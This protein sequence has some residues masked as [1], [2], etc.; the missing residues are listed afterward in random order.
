MQS[1]FF[2]DQKEK[3][4]RVF[5]PEL[6]SPEAMAV[7]EGEG[8]GTSGMSEEVAALVEEDD[9]SEEDALPV[10]LPLLGLEDLYE[11]TV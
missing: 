9:G 1:E 3:L 5:S 2:H 8:E 4:K 6:S 11:A 10:P 7:E